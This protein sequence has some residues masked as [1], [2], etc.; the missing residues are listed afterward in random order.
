MMRQMKV[1]VIQMMMVESLVRMIMYMNEGVC[2]V[3]KVMVV[4]NNQGRQEVGA[5]DQ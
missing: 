3:M 2:M 4:G 5:A 1:E